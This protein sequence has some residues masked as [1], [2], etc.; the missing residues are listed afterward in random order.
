V[1]GNEFK[2]LAERRFSDDLWRE[3][4]DFQQQVMDHPPSGLGLREKDRYL[5]GKWFHDQQ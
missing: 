4:E 2:R 3:H 5:W 1:V